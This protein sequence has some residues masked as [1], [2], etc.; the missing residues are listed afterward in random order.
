MWLVGGNKCISISRVIAICCCFCSVL[1]CLHPIHQY[2]LTPLLWDK[3][4]AWIHK[5]S[6]KQ[7]K[8]TV[9]LMP[10]KQKHLWKYVA[11]TKMKC[12]M[13]VHHRIHGA[14]FRAALTSRVPWSPQYSTP[15]F[16]TSPFLS[17]RGLS[18]IPLGSTIPHCPAPWLHLQPWSPCDP[19]HG[20]TLP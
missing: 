1:I 5:L 2:F 6:W 16:K 20:C 3:E 17:L 11:Y 7:I 18:A 4:H 8:C 10:S 9:Q 19:S 15:R 14:S 13:D 12:F